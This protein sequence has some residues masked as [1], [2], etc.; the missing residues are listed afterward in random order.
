MNY[1]K[2]MMHL[3][4]GAAIVMG[5]IAATGHGE[6]TGKT[7]TPATAARE[8]FVRTD[9][10]EYRQGEMISVTIENPTEASIFCHVGVEGIKHI[11]KRTAEGGWEKLFAMC[12]PPHCLYDMGPP[13][14]IGPGGARTFEWRPL[15]YLG[16]TSKTVRATPAAYRLSVLYQD[17]DRKEWR[18]AYSN[19]FVI[20]NP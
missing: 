16:G 8:V 12:Q 5:S 18:S 14:E 4:L 1:L 17:R 15:I 6:P 3:L 9:R 11:E 2:K 19:I 20:G 13:D 7:G 10:Q